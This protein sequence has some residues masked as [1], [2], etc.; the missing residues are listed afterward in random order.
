MNITAS[1]CVHADKAE[2]YFNTLCKHFARKV[3]VQRDGDQARVHFPMGI[4]D[5]AVQGTALRFQCAAADEA[6]LL[7]V[8]GIIASH[9]TLFGEMKG[10]HLDWQRVQRDPG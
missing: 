7:A 1:T 10:A 9:V 6:A 5:M 4:C 3:R 8:Q 2:R